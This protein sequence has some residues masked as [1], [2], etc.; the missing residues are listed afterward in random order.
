INTAPLVFEGSR[1]ER[2]STTCRLYLPEV[3]PVEGA[4][5]TQQRRGYAGGRFAAFSEP[6]S[7]AEPLALITE[8]RG[9]FGGSRSR[10]E[11]RPSRAGLDVIDK[12]KP[13]GNDRPGCPPE[14]GD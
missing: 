13:G 4:A 6:S 2:L 7:Q 8:S 14:A 12:G 5:A 11:R 3:A 9:R 1:Y 10:A